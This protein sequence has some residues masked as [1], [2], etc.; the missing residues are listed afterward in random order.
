LQDGQWTD[1]EEAGTRKTRVVQLFSPEYFELLR[2]DPTFAR[3]Q[4]LGWALSINVGQQRVLVEKDGKQRDE[5]LR[6]RSQPSG[7]NAPGA[8][9]VQQNPQQ[10]IDQRNQA[11]TQQAPRRPE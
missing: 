9:Q 5:S 7:Q 1:A 4:Q 2:G 6:K 3:A 11:P 8:N 10:R